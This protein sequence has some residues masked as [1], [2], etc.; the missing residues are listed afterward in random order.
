[1]KPKITEWIPFLGMV[2]YFKRYWI[3]PKPSY[4]DVLIAEW[5]Y[6]LPYF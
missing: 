6:V 1:M 2:T 5:V 4:R 3:K